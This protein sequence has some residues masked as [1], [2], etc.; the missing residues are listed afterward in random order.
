MTPRIEKLYRYIRD[1]KMTI[2]TE[3]AKLFTEAYKRYDGDP[4]VVRT[5]KAQA[6]MLDNINIFILD[7]DLIAGA[8]ASKPLGLEADFWTRG[9]WRKEGVE[10]LREEGSHYISDESAADMEEL[11]DYWQHFTAEYKMLDLFDSKMWAWK[12]SGFH[13][14]RNKTIEEAAGSGLALSSLSIFPEQEFASINYEFALKTGLRANVEKAKQKL[15]E[16]DCFDLKTDYDV[17]RVY[18]LR[19]MVIVNEA[20]IRWAHRYADLAEQMAGKSEDPVRKQELLDMAESC[21]RV[22]EYP[23]QTF[24]DALHFQWFIYI[25]THYMNVMPLGRVDQYMYPYFKHDME[26]GTL[27]EEKAL[28]YLQCLRLKY[29]QIRSTSGGQHRKKWSGQA[30]W[31]GATLGGVKPDGSDATNELSYLFLEAAMRCRT[32]H[33]TITLRVHKNTPPKLM[34][35]AIELVKTG[36]GMPSFVSDEGYIKTLTDKGVPL[37]VARDY[38][39][40]GCLDVTVPEGWGQ[41]FSMCCNALPF[42]T[43]LHNGYSPIEDHYVGPQTGDPRQMKTFDELMDKLVEHYTWY[44][45]CYA[46]DRQIR[47]NIRRS[48]RFLQDVLA[49]SLYH[50]G[51]DVGCSPFFRKMPYPGL[52]PA[53]GIGVGTVNVGDSLA[54]IK[55]LVFD[56]K[57]VT[58]DELINALDSNWEGE[59]NQEI[60]RMCMAIPKYGND[61][62]E[63]DSIVAELY[64]RLSDVI[65]DMDSYRG[66]KYCVA[67]I[68]ITSHEPGGKLVGATPDGRY[69]GTILAD[70]AG[71]PS[72]GMD[73]NGPTA[74]LN[75]ALKIP[76]EKL[77]SL[78]LNMK[79]HPNALKTKEDVEKLGALIHT[80]LDH[81][82]KQIQFNV[83]SPEV[84]KKA[85]ENPDQYRDLIVRVAGYSTYFTLLSESVQDEIIRRTTVEAL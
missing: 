35:K 9:C 18:A 4:D 7:G 50:D 34:E 76:Q 67:A 15:S 32:P 49:I 6:Y 71:S 73:R 77:N 38:Y 30:A 40:V 2:C 13:L 57:L 5:A 21:R 47:F 43:F 12:K 22:P 64:G 68:S 80:Y 14:P 83:V 46:A 58:M 72:Q 66:T 65:L 69:A 59:R 52:G 84:L 20:A 3:K 55:K 82:G 85:K 48:Q 25:L 41:L 60:R 62:E 31:R 70:G 37:E 11:A 54:A 44:F 36:I 33:H 56:E 63:T 81:G 8:P 27:D 75:S 51:V 1:T 17:D 23:A 39:I 45:K 19:A 29:M 28:E 26:A 53:I 10:S 42:D 74:V 61:D 79:I 24:L 78:L 16:I